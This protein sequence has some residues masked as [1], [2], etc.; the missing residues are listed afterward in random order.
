M[1][2]AMI[3]ARRPLREVFYGWREGY[4]YAAIQADSDERAVELAEQYVDGFGTSNRSPGHH[5]TR[6]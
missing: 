4:G 3:L 2:E 5:P 6:L 1:R